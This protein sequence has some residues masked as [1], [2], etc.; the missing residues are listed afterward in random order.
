M[1]DFAAA[2]GRTRGAMHPFVKNLMAKR[3]DNCP[4]CNSAR[5]NP[6]KLVSKAVAFHGKYC[7]F[8]RAWQEVYG[9]K[10]EPGA[11]SGSGPETGRI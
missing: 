4:L 3:C 9:E 7:P 11:G 10:K 1:L 8:W 6:D 2:P 5:R